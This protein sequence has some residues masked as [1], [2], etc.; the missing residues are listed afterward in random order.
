MSLGMSQKNRSEANCGPVGP[1][2]VSDNWSVLGK[3]GPSECKI[4]PRELDL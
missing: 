1:I 2:L 4:L 3:I